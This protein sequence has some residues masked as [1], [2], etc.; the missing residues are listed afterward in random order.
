MCCSAGVGRSGTFITL[1]IE[2]QRAIKE[3]CVD[4]FNTVCRLREQRSNMVQTEAQYI[5]LHDAILE[6]VQTNQTEVP[7]ERLGKYMRGLEATKKGVSGYN[8]EFKVLAYTLTM[9]FSFF[10]TTH[11]LY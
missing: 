5:F 2:L 9:N 6:G 3:K 7:L 1:D 10:Y 8:K 11:L 4:P